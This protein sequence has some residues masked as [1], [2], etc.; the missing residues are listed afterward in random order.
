MT[1]DSE[2][3]TMAR[4]DVLTLSPKQH[5]LLGHALALAHTL[6]SQ[7]GGTGLG[8]AVSPASWA[9]LLKP[10]GAAGARADEKA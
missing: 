5:Q 7:M 2:R 6:H 1:S 10:R 9:R 3:L 4:D 8:V